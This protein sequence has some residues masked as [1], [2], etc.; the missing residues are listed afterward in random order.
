MYTRISTHTYNEKQHDKLIKEK[1]PLGIGC[2]VTAVLNLSLPKL[3]KCGSSPA[4]T[5]RALPLAS[6]AI[7]AFLLSSKPPSFFRLLLR[8][9]LT[10]TLLTPLPA[11]FC[12]SSLAKTISASSIIS[13]EWN[14]RLY[15]YCCCHFYVISICTG[16]KIR[17]T[18]KTTFL[19]YYLVFTFY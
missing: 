1:I 2:K 7:P 10:T 6:T 12:S 18:L 4:W 15:Q 14:A 19:F 3:T 17:P 9:L 11:F 16:F 13:E 5:F 8:I